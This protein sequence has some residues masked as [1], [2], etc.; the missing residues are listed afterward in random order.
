[1][2]HAQ[3]RMRLS[4]NVPVVFIDVPDIFINVPY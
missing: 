3:Q 4:D 2:P 1:M